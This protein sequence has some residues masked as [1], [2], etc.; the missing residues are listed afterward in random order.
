MGTLGCRGR[1]TVIRLACALVVWLELFLCEGGHVLNSDLCFSADQSV[2]LRGVVYGGAG[3]DVEF[4]LCKDGHAF[5][6]LSVSCELCD[7]GSSSGAERMF[8]AVNNGTVGSEVCGCHFIAESMSCE[9]CQG[10]MTSG[11]GVEEVKNDNGLVDMCVS[12]QY[13]T[14]PGETWRDVCGVDSG[15][16]VRACSTCDGVVVHDGELFDLRV[17]PGTHCAGSSDAVCE[18][19]NECGE[20]EYESESCGVEAWN[21]RCLSCEVGRVSECVSGVGATTYVSGC[22]GGFEGYCESCVERGDEYCG[23]SEYL[24]GCGGTS[25]GECVARR[26]DCGGADFP[27][28][29]L[30]FSDVLDAGHCEAC[31]SCGRGG[32]VSGCVGEVNVVDGGECRQCSV[33]VTCGEGHYISGCGGSSAGAC[34]SCGECPYPEHFVANCGGLE[35]GECLPCWN[36]TTTVGPGTLGF[37]SEYASFWMRGCGPG[38]SA[39]AVSLCDGTEG[40]GSTMRRCGDGERVVGCGYGFGGHCVDCR[41]EVCGVNERLFSCGSDGWDGASRWDVG[42]LD[43][44]CRSCDEGIPDGMIETPCN[45]CVFGCTD[46]EGG[47]VDGGGGLVCGDGFERVSC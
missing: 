44:L 12:C 8:V 36:T 20:F 7:D 16:L 30:S 11:S 15:G 14:I 17:R 34:E 4:C 2:L 25:G 35:A 38:T 9:S 27:L 5:V 21:R 40:G 47:G 10:S 22:G 43:G 42:A 13:G 33:D 19:C 39:G 24:S 3:G 37:P 18:V 41:G 45:D 28:T 1:E 46:A 26:T 6:A 32:Y 23:E 31:K 29:Y